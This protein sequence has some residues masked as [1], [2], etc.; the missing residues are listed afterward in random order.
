MNLIIKGFI[1]NYKK[2]YL[3][4]NFSVCWTYPTTNF[5]ISA[6]TTTTLQ[7]VFLVLLPLT[8]FS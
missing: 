4:Y 1:K 6:Y 2:Q 5:L 3:W 7:P 8:I